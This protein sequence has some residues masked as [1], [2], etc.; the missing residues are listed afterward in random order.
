MMKLDLDRSQSGRSQLDVTDRLTLRWPER[1]E[2]TVDLTGLLTL[3]N[4]QDRVLLTGSVDATLQAQC[5]RC[6]EPFSLTFVVPVE[7]MVL[8]DTQTEDESDTC[9]IHQKTGEVDLRPPLQELTL[10]AFPQKRVCRENCRGFC[11]QC[12]VNLNEQECHCQGEE[13]D[14]RWEDLPS[15]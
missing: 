5:D 10:L 15:D 11:P 7:I 9:V 4:L 13:V 12:G 3:D 1:D 14:P 8:R 2:E 6:L